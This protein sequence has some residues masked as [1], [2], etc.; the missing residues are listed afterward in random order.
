MLPEDVRRLAQLQR[1]VVTAAQ[2]RAAGLSRDVARSRLQSGRW[3]QVHHGVYAVFTGALGRETTLW[4]VVLRAGS[5]ATLSHD[6][7]A[8]L[9][10]LID[11]PSALIHVT[12]P[13]SRRVIPVAGVVI[14]HAV[15]VELTRHPVKLPP[16]T[17]IEDTVLD[18]A[19]RSASSE[20]ACAWIARA[21]GRR[22]TTQDKLS[23]ALDQRQRIRFRGELARML[24]PDLAGIHSALEH[25][26]LRWVE[27]PHGL[28]HGKR[29]VR[30]RRDDH[31]EYRDVL[32]E[33]HGLIVELDGRAAHPGDRR[34]KDIWRDN[35]AAADG[36]R[37]L[38]YGWDDLTK[39]P[40][41]VAAQVVLALSRSGPVTARPCSPG[42]PVSR[43][44]R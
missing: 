25:R 34:W 15:R 43:R 3:Q 5:A 18:L 42:C 36:G 6:T 14:H 11:R 33:D 26:Y 16:R 21:L 28:R 37:T 1:G 29:Q 22:L 40:C 9:H 7:A 8:E 17:R 31:T 23:A 12:I 19:R 39:R 20:D 27:V 44:V 2:L 30:V 32:Y 24:S 35:A 10:G 4:A 38:R 13:E 41:L